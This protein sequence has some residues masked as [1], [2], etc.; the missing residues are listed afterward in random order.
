M[1]ILR[2]CHKYLMGH[3]GYEVHVQNKVS[4]SSDE[5]YVVCFVSDLD[6]YVAK[7][8][9]IKFDGYYFD[10]KTNAFIIPILYEK[11]KGYIEDLN[12]SVNKRRFKK[13]FKSILSSIKPDL[14]HIHG[15]LLPQFLYAAR[16]CKKAVATHHI[17]KPNYNT[18]Y[19]LQKF[20]CHQ[21]MPY[22]CST[23]YAVSSYSKKTFLLRGNVVVRE[24]KMEIILDES[25]D[26]K[27]LLKRNLL[28]N[29]FTINN[30]DT[31]YICPA[32]FT[33]NKNQLRLVK[34]F[35]KLEHN[36][37]LILV[38]DVNDNEY[39]N[40][41]LKEIKDDKICVLPEVS[42]K[43]VLALYS[44]SNVLAFPSINEGYGLVVDEAKD[45]VK[46]VSGRRNSKRT[47]N[48]N[49]FNVSS[50]YSGLQK[51]LDG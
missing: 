26:T 48:I 16:V 33:P 22:Y 20:F 10:S 25:I 39:Y 21:L 12:S 23:V 19:G 11:R 2:L 1:K 38:G 4:S 9:L 24:P 28:D 15:T 34:A 49:P 40:K 18:R 14:V 7:N 42:H 47:I 27:D 31:V 5:E 30:R 45:L 43:E 41:V 29:N 37:K 50:I 6:S 44:I 17:G 46:V 8:D 13:Q 51:V 35:N 32:R 3:D 36:C